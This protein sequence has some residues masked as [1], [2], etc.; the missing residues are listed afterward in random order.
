MA[1]STEEKINLELLENQLKK[2]LTLPY[3]WG[4]KQTDEW[5][6][7]TKFIYSTRSFSQ[8]QKNICKLHLK[9]QNY[10]L[11][12][13]LNY[14]SAKAIEQIF[15]YHEKITPHINKYDK[16]IDFFIGNIA[17]DHK[18]SVFPKGFTKGFDY[19]LQNKRELII[20]LYD[21]QSQEGRKHHKNRIF[22]VLYDKTNAEHWKLKA[23]IHLIQKVIDTYV[24]SFSVSNLEQLSFGQKT[25]FSNIIW[26]IK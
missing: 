15:S 3:L 18:T 10:A 9:L 22:V 7:E 1:N 26:V 16:E 12:R 8:L 21:K 20:W 23:E 25:I 14:W 24:K 2:R 11:N 19:A 6:K 13:W 17:F 5:D 4:R